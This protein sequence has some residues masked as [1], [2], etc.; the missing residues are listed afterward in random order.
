MS[1]YTVVLLRPEYISD[2]TG[3]TY[4][5]DI[6]VALV[7]ADGWI[8]AVS[9]ARDEVFAS[10]LKDELPIKKSEDYVFCVLFKGHHNPD[11]FG[12]QFN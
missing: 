3:R 1:N 8:S 4:G 9:V 11:F 7:E 12:F 2:E 5:K 6:Y 10:D